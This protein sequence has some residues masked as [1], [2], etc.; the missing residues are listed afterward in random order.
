MET[1]EV[2]GNMQV[3]QAVNERS[4]ELVH[5][6]LGTREEGSKKDIWIGGLEKQ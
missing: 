3:M 4:S 6:N 1:Q 5:G 2:N